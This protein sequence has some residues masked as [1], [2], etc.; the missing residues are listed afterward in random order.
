MLHGHLR[1][2]TAGSP[3]SLSPQVRLRLSALLPVSVGMAGRLWCPCQRAEGGDVAPQNPLRVLTELV[4][5]PES[6]VTDD[7]VDRLDHLGGLDT[8]VPVGA[9]SSATAGLLRRL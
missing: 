2:I 3:Q 9:F 7:G 5:L 8:S 4:R 6:T 1:T